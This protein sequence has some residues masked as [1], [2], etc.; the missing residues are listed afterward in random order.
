MNADMDFVRSLAD[1]LAVHT[2]QSSGYFKHLIKSFLRGATGR[3]RLEPSVKDEVIARL[4]AEVDNDVPSFLQSYLLRQL[5]NNACPPEAIFVA[6][7]YLRRPSRERLVSWQRRQQLI[8]ELAGEAVPGTELGFR[9]M[10]YSQGAATAFRWHGVPCFKSCNDIATYAMLIDELRPGS[11]I[12][13]GSG[14]GGSALL[15]AD[16]CASAG[17][18]T[19]IT[20]V[21]IEVAAVSD[22]R[23]SFV[24]CDCSAWL[25]TTAQSGQ[26]FRR[27]CL[28]IEDF[29]DDLAGFFE[30]IDS[31]LDSGDYLVI[32]DSSTKQNQIAKVIAGRPYLV[33]TKYTDFF[34]VNCSSAMNSIFVK[35]PQTTD[36]RD[37]VRPD[38][39]SAAKQDRAWRERSK[40]QA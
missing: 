4:R 3:A 16:L 21:D 18:T 7:Q 6:L 19:E 28:L 32:E 14:A 1:F 31:I 29:H 33:D 23:I 38:Y 15:F 9:Q 37:A 24:R 12:E 36:S 17:L 25:Q 22:P 5:E 39:K 13:L 26:T 30:S 10:L 34:G 20:S 8:A 11:I 2:E 40:R 27:P 35:S